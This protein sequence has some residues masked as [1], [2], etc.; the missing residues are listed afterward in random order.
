LYLGGRRSTTSRLLS[1][2]PADFYSQFSIWKE[3]HLRLAPEED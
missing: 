3:K 2:V 1:A